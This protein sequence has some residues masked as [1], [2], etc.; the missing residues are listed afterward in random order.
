MSGVDEMLAKARAQIVCYTSA[1]AWA[2]EDVLLV[3]LRP[4]DVRAK[5]GLA[6]ASLMQLGVDAGD[7]E[8]G[9]DAWVEAGLPVQ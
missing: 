6:A 2:A 9:F 5:T 1:E 3:D 7:L 4:D 8:G